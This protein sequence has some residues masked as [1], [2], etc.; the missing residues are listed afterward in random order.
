MN[1]SLRIWLQYIDNLS[2]VRGSLDQSSWSAFLRA[3]S[4]GVD[5]R[6]AFEQVCERIRAA[7]DHPRL[8]KLH[9][10]LRRA[11][12]FT[13]T[14]GALRPYEPSTGREFKPAF[15]S[16]FAE[17]FAGQV[18][19]ITNKWLR[20]Q[21]KVPLLAMTPAEF[22]WQVYDV[23]ERIAIFT[24][25]RG[26]GDI[27]SKDK[28]RCDR[29]EL[30][31]F[32][33]GHPAGVWFLPQPVDGMD[34]YNPRQDRMSRRS[35]ESITSFRFAVLESDCQPVEQWLRILVQLPLPIVAITASGGKSV[36]CAY[37]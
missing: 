26:Q 18:P 6:A 27:W 32:V 16:S 22:L 28:L 15:N 25:Q 33:S 21:S 19:P 29:C 2:W 12:E 4:L 13:K 35:E 8:P 37:R 23:G 3:G 36:H 7:G 34:H 9:N 17:K 11:F 1:T 30:H 24:D 5:S 20:R 31:H 10:Q 14:A